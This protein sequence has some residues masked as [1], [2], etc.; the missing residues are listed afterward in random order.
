LELIIPESV[1]GFVRISLVL[2]HELVPSLRE[3]F[4]LF[5]LD[6]F[7]VNE[8]LVLRVAHALKL[9]NILVL[10]EDVHFFFTTLSFKII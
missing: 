4:K 8:F 7:Y 10:L 2:C 3:F 6:L 9:A 5:T 1:N